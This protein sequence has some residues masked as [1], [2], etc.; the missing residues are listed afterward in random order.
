MAAAGV[1]FVV[2]EHRPAITRTLK[3]H[4]EVIRERIEALAGVPVRSRHYC[5]AEDFDA[6]AVV[7]SGSFAP[8]AEHDAVALDRLGESVRRFGGPVLG[9]C[10]GMQL[11]AMFAGGAIGPRERPAVGFAPVEILDDGDLLGGLGL[12]AVTYEHHSWDVVTLPENF[13]VLAR[14]EDCAVEAVR[15]RDRPWWGTQFH[16]EQ[17]SVEHPDGARVL[18]NFFALA[19]IAPDPAGE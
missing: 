4:Y 18:R 7:L 10:G 16:P 12:T 6:A 5:D 17:F 2:T 14:S 19:G 8:W 1:E 3:R 15:A 11:Q 13:V 9:I